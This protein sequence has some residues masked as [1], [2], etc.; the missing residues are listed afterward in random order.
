MLSLTI[1]RALRRATPAFV[2]A[3]AALTLIGSAFG[4][5]PTPEAMLKQV[6]QYEGIGQFGRA[7]DLLVPGQRKLINRDR[8][9]TCTG[10]ALKT[11]DSFRV[12][13]FKKIDQYRDPVHVTGVTQTPVA[14]ASICQPE[15]TMNT[16]FSH[17]SPS[18][19]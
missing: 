12:T 2:V 15:V 10:N 4:G 6:L 3:A 16:P 13:S 7:Y 14:A 18:A 1:G 19:T 11:F 5:T 17:A 8:F 9:I